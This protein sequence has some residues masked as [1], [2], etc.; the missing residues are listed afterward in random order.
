MKQ[1]YN[2]SEEHYDSGEE[3]Y[4]D[5]DEEENKII[6]KKA[7]NK[8]IKKTSRKQSLSFDEVQM[9]LL[10]YTVTGV[11]FIFIMEQFVQIGMKLKKVH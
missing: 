9:E 7:N 8:K 2:E 5:D 6:K 4:S 10:L 11:I 3:N 1:Y